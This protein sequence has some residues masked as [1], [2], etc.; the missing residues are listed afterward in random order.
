MKSKK[1]KNILIKTVLILVLALGF[2]S[3]GVGSSS[4]L[5]SA[6]CSP[7]AS[8]GTDTMK[9]SIPSQTTYNIWVRMITPTAA[10]NSVYLQADNGFC[11][12]VGGVSLT[13]NTWTWVDY[14]NGSTSSTMSTSLTAGTHTITLT[15]EQPS[16][17]VDNI[18]FLSSNSVCTPNG[19]PTGNGS[20]CTVTTPPTVSIQTPCV[21][22][23]VSGVTCPTNVSGTQT[24]SA[25]AS[26]TGTISSVVFQIDGTTVATE[27]T[28]SSGSTYSTSWNSSSVSN[29]THVLKVIATDTETL[30]TS[31]AETI[32]VENN[33][34]TGNPTAPTLSA[35]ANGSSSINLSWT[36][37]TPATDCSISSYALYRG[38]TLLDQSIPANTLSYSDSGLAQNTTYSYHVVATDSSGHTAT[39]NTASATT[40]PVPPP[41]PPTTVTDALSTTVNTDV[42]INWSAVNDP[43]ATISGYNVYRSGVKINTSGLVTGLSYTDT[44]AQP[45]STYTYS[46]SSVDQYGNESATQTD[47]NPSPI[48]IPSANPAQPP[49]MPTAFTVT[50][51]A[52][53]TISFSWT[54]STDNVAITDYFINE[55]NSSKVFV[56][57]VTDA[58]PVSGT[59]SFTVSNLTPSTTYYFSVEAYNSDKQTGPA[60][61]EISAATTASPYPQ[62]I[63]GDINGDGR[64]DYLDLSVLMSH[65]GQSCMAWSCGDI[66]GALGDPVNTN[67]L[68]Q[69]INHWTSTLSPVVTPVKPYT[70]VYTKDNDICTVTNATFEVQIWEYSGSTPVNTVEGWLTWDPTYIAP[71][72]HSF[73][74]GMFNGVSAKSNFIQN[75]AGQDTQFEFAR[76]TSGDNLINDEYIGEITF[77]ALKAGNTAVLMHYHGTGIATVASS[78]DTDPYPYGS[79]VHIGASAPPCTSSNAASGGILLPLSDPLTYSSTA[80]SSSASSASEENTALAGAVSTS[81][82]PVVSTLPATKAPTTSSTSNDETAMYI[83]PQGNKTAMPLTSRSSFWVSVP[84]ILVPAPALNGQQIKSVSY[85]LNN[86]LETIKYGNGLAYKLNTTNLANGN[87]TLT[88]KEILSDGSSRNISETMEVANPASIKQLYLQSKQYLWLIIAVIVVLL[89]SLFA[90]KS[91]SKKGKAS[92]WSQVAVD[93]DVRV[94]PQK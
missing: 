59:N 21:S 27:T 45:G 6:A 55:Y 28:P 62:V 38:T 31:V 53:T 70:A 14:Q 48:T 85:Y 47:A 80:S 88:A 50:A 5:A 8:L 78:V 33:S 2:A 94:K 3:F 30:S 61:A 7:D 81:T 63:A 90:Q 41:N 9:V 60:T 57:Q 24:L 4:K 52:P 26:D 56:T 34:C 36:A 10:D 19:V 67:D 39:S 22:T 29:G 37:S 51:K 68:S 75:S 93:P 18:L 73:V 12:S 82:A 43:N 87:Y 74:G 11:T 69:M 89:V 54:A 66:D 44:T 91:L 77:T 64:I 25:N 49:T 1:L 40:T 46:V 92:K 23:A 42:N 20:N 86:S 83:V 65:W 76:G 72:S 84:P 35:T 32:N 13:P 79:H 17:G 71:V 15:G 16:V 58:D